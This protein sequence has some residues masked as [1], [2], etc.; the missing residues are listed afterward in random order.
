MKNDV[1]EVVAKRSGVRRESTLKLGAYNKN[2]A[3][4]SVS[5]ETGNG[6]TLPVKVFL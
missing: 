4:G 1:V 3:L 2:N 5:Q 6:G